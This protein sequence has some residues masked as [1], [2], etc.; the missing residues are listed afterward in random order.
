MFVNSG[1]RLKFLRTTFACLPFV[2][3]AVLAYLTEVY[4]A[5]GLSGSSYVR[6]Y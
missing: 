5:L 3:F 1:A 2:L 6:V 4:Q